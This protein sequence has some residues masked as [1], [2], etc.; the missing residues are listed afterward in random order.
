MALGEKTKLL[1]QNPIYRKKMSDAKKGKHYSNS[2]KL[3][4]KINLGKIY[5]QERR[6]KI[7]KANTGKK[8]SEESKKKMS[9]Y[10]IGKKTKPHTLE[11]RLKMSESA[12]KIVESGKHI[13]WK[14][15]IS[16]I[17]EKIRSSLKYKLW[18]ETIFKRD[19]W[20]CLWCGVKGGT[21]IKKEKKKIILNAD[22]IKPFSLYPEL[23]FAIDN[24]RT[25][26]VD[27]HRSTETFGLK[28]R[29]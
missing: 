25:L 28:H 19:N 9:F 15:G 5:S 21:W 22:H 18:R 3:G 14:G 8:H 13:F 6:Q 10:R 11:T 27:C 17:N 12:K 16:S 24:G 2:F 7:S 1:W 29:I 20:I 23:R 4:H 26:C